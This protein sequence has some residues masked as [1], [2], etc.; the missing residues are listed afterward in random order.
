M[1]KLLKSL[2]LTLAMAS[3]V[4][5]AGC[6]L[7][8]GNSG[9]DSSDN[10]SYCGSDGFYRC[11]GNDCNWVGATCPPDG[12]GSGGSNGS[13]YEC[14][15]STDCA[16][17]CYCA[18]GTCEEGGFCGSDGDCGAGYHCNTDRS[19]CEPNPTQPTCGAD[20]DCPTGQVCDTTQGTC[21]A[22]CT[23]TTDAGAVQQG[24]GWCDETRNTCMT[25]EDPAGSCGGT[26]TC[27]TAKPSC[28]DNQVPLI[29]DGCYTGACQAIA[30]CDATPACTEL[31]HE[32]DCLGRKTDCSA[33]YTG[34]NCKKPDGSAC[35]A[36][37]TGCTCAS[38]VFN[39]CAAKGTAAQVVIDSAGRQIAVPRSLM[40]Q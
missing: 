18:S 5:L 4:T 36:G 3:A 28:P 12:S 34:L 25:G 38:F 2:G 7:Y 32:D 17:G 21:T 8:F 9:D 30:T 27:T 24:F 40:L 19:S 29:L 1:T 16:A 33:V 15:S 35:H 39:S 11:T 31:G 22:T 26:S 37:D 14:T 13:G 6:E 23:C 20:A 10:W